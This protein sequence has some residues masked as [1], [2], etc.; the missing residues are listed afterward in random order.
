MYAPTV[1]TVEHSKRILRYLR[2]TLLTKP[3]AGIHF[4]PEAF[5]SVPE[6]LTPVAYADSDHARHA[7]RRSR[8]GTVILFCGAPIYR[9]SALQKTIQLH[10]ASAEIVA[11][12]DSAKKVVWIV[13]LLRAL[14]FS[15]RLAG[16]DLRGQHPR[17]SHRPS[18]TSGSANSGSAAS[19]RARR[20]ER[21]LGGLLHQGPPRGLLPRPPPSTRNLWLTISNTCFLVPFL[22]PKE[23][24]CLPLFLFC[25]AF[26]WKFSPASTSSP[27]FDSLFPSRT[28]SRLGHPSGFPF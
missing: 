3:A 20:D 16:S 12:S 5:A 2:G 9:R 4:T 25:L 10:S 11:P 14:G 8:S 26:S 1:D 23:K 27:P 19:Y 24:S 15:R 6:A 13:S 28:S 18:V 22:M 7:S 21:Q 17:Y